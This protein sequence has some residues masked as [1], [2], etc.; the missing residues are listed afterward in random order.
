MRYLKQK[1]SLLLTLRGSN[2]N[3]NTKQINRHVW[4][5][6]NLKASVSTAACH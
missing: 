2:P 1:K 3:T 4:N 6:K 5:Y